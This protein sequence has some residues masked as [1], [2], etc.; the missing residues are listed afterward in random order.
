M[1]FSLYDED[2]HLV[3]TRCAGSSFSSSI[4]F[5]SWCPGTG[6]EAIE[7]YSLQITMTDTWGDGWNDNVLGLRQNNFIVGTFGSDFTTGHSLGPKTV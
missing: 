1:S 3:F 6:C 5:Y 2:S 7:T 4:I